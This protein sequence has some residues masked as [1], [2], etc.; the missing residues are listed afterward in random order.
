MPVR[1]RKQLQHWWMRV[2][3]VTA[4]PGF[5]ATRP[6]AGWVPPMDGQTNRTLQRCS[7]NLHGWTHQGWTDPS[8]FDRVQN[9]LEWTAKVTR[10]KFRHFRPAKA[11]S[12]DDLSR[13][14]S[15]A[16]IGGVGKKVA[17]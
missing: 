12:K 3:L 16:A 4:F 10:H 5:A 9:P 6:K 14:R 7:Q 11:S 2:L 1:A 15:S 13:F 17:S 8:A